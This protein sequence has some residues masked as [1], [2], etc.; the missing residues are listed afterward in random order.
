MVSCGP[1]QP[2]ILR[3]T[4]N[5]TTD[6]AVKV[7]AEVTIYKFVTKYKSPTAGDLRHDVQIVAEPPNS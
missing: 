5:N 3:K 4:S 6:F 1:C 7:I 2:L